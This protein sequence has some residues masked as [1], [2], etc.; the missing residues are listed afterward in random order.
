MGLPMIVCLGA[1]LCCITFFFLLSLS[2]CI[3]IPSV[4]PRLSPSF[5]TYERHA[6]SADCCPLQRRPRLFLLTESGHLLLSPPAPCY[7]TKERKSQFICIL[8]LLVLSGLCS[9]TQCKW[10]ETLLPFCSENVFS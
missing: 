8:S 10:R 4:F 5:V 6:F 7:K 2:F 3:S 1:I 9:S